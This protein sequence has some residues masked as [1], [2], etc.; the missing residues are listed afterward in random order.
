MV[1][2]S[3]LIP[4]LLALGA[5][6]TQE[7]RV[8]HS[9]PLTTAEAAYQESDLLDV[10]VVAFEAGVP[11]GELTREQLEELMRDGTYVQIRRAE[12][13]FLAVKLRETL[14]RSGH[15]GAVRVTPADSN[16][17]DV[18][19]HATILQSDGNI[20]QLEAS[21]VDATG[22]VWFENE[23]SMET[24]ASAYNSQRYPNLDP[25]QDV[26][27]E[28]AND[29][30][31]YRAGLDGA[32]VARIR[33]VGELRYASELS[34]EAFGDYLEENRSGVFEPVRLPADGDPM[35]RRARNVR[36][37]EQLFFETMDQYYE[38]FAIDAT[39]SY[40]SWREFSRE[41]SIRLQEAA[42]A[43]KLR[44]GLGALAIALSI[45]YGTQSDGNS[46]QDMMVS[47]AGIYIGNDLLRSAS[48]RRRERELH[49]QSLQ[50]QSED[51]DDT[52]KPMV[53]EV[54]GTQH[55]LTGTTEMQL[56]AWKDM[57]RDLFI[58]ETGLEADE[59]VVYSEVDPLPDDNVLTESDAAAAE[60]AADDDMPADVAAEQPPP[61]ALPTTGNGQPAVPLIAPSTAD[62]AS[63]AAG[64]AP[65]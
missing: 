43:A 20:F 8:P 39:D 38:N 60:A 51:F 12:S 18:T 17:L 31:A 3:L 16:A 26:L 27:N 48:V 36:Q 9:V 45:A 4:V 10:G 41:D 55:R 23:Y 62:T 64:A 14:Q 33:T 32:T 42:R 13:M 58:S 53:V 44:T 56:E 30:A 7:V 34:P 50:E 54:S 63:G 35:L 2:T 19:V 46:F 6:T 11:E 37:S 61:P 59:I 47:E 57:M 29:L 28:I 49:T 21:A 24:A 40:R 25:Y 52:V 1:R 15:W 22:R 5:C 65:I